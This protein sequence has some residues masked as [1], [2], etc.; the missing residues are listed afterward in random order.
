MLLW[1]S[2]IRKGFGDKHT[3]TAPCALYGEQADKGHAHDGGNGCRQIQSRNSAILQRA[4]EKGK[5][6][7][8]RTQQCQ[9]QTYTYRHCLGQKKHQ[10]R[11][12]IQNFSIKIKIIGKIFGFLHRKQ[13]AECRCLIPVVP[14]R[15][16]PGY[17]LVAFFKA[18]PSYIR[19]I[20]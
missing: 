18:H 5:K 12:T 8:G 9:E 2:A 16:A 7:A 3:F 14:L 11:H 13:G 17:V 1:N 20:M 4:T 15:S 19:V 6:E 10:V